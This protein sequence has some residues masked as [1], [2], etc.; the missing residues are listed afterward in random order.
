MADDRSPI[1]TSQQA[2]AAVIAV[3]ERSAGSG[4]CFTPG[5]DLSGLIAEGAGG[6][7]EA[8][9]LVL[10]DGSV[11]GLASRDAGVAGGDEDDVIV[12][13]LQSAL[14]LADAERRTAAA[15]A[16]AAEAEEESRLDPLTGL[17]NRRA[18]ELTLVHEQARCRR[19]GG[20]AVVLVLDVDGL[21]QANDAEGHLAGDLLLRT[22][23]AA[24]ERCVREGDVVARLGGDEFG[25]L[26][27]DWAG[28]V[29]ESLVVRVTE[30]LENAGVAASVGGAVPEL[31]ESL[32][33]TFHRA[34]GAMYE[35]KRHRKASAASGSSPFDPS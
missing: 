16:R 13:L 7:V 15:E 10:P 23:A 18:W 17:A 1:T 26:A 2:M 31:G 28:P 5:A 24:H 33:T 27:V 11:I 35:T 20:R 12:A 34:D 30:A 22:T 9:P 25:V 21:K 4:W 6:A 3:I 29:P 14:A 32:L 8:W 19:T